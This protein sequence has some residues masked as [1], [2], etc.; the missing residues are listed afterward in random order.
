MGNPK[1]PLDGARRVVLGTLLERLER[2]PGR[3]WAGFSNHMYL[4]VPDFHYT[5]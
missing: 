1:L 5:Y 3:I 4:K 2:A